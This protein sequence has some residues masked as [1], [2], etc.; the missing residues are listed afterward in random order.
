MTVLDQTTA[1]LELAKLW[2]GD[3]AAHTRYNAT[4]PAAKVLSK[5]AA[6][7]RKLAGEVAP[8]WVPLSTV[9]Q[10]SG[11]SEKALR[12]I[13][14]DLKK[15]GLARKKSGKWEIALA[16]AL[17]IPRVSESIDLTQIKDI[18]EMARLLGQEE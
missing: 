6:D 15:K 1:L 18:D 2:E 17:Q 7:V 10:T 13:C 5:C 3:A 16:A 8:E 11:R 9:R 4:D 12:A 14:E